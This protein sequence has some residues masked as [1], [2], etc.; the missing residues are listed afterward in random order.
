MTPWGYGFGQSAQQNER[1]FLYTDSPVYR[2]GHTVHIKG[3]LRKEQNDTL[4]LPDEKTVTLT[5]SGPDDKR[6]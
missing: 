6:S 3:I 5:V 2:P 4:L 1:A